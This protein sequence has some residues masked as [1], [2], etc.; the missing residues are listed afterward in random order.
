[1]KYLWDVDPN[2]TGPLAP[3]ADCSGFVHWLYNLP[4]VLPQT[5]L[6]YNSAR[7][8]G[9]LRPVDQ[10][11]PGDMLIHRIGFD[12]ATTGH[13]AFYIGDEGHGPQTIEA[14]SAHTTPQMGLFPAFTRQWEAS[15]AVD[16]VVRVQ[17]PAPLNLAAFVLACRAQ[18]LKVGSTGS[19]VVFWQSLMGIKQDGIYGQATEQSTSV[20]QYLFRTN[21]AKQGIVDAYLLPVTGVVDS[22]TWAAKLDVS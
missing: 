3:G 22:H 6:L 17:P 7:V 18:T 5:L 19:A 16:E 21:E 4:W 12:G 13:V 1:M 8:R 14:H 20:F 10:A 11:R 15:I 9:A 2:P